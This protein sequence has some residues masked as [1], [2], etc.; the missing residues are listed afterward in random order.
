MNHHKSLKSLL[1]GLGL[2]AFAAGVGAQTEPTAPAQ[3]E[4]L[5]M[6]SF[7][8]REAPLDVVLG[9]LRTLTGKNVTADPDI[10]ATFTLTSSGVVT[11]EEAVDLITRALADQGLRIVDVDNRTL[12]VVRDADPPS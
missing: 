9:R 3:G 2:A 11:M 6:V 7:H 4:P 12:Q 5:A 1:L 8:F 10:R